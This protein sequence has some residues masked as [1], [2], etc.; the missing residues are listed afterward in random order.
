MKLEDSGVDT[1]VA[2]LA[3]NDTAAHDEDGLITEI[4]AFFDPQQAKPSE[5]DPDLRR[6]NRDRFRDRQR[7]QNVPLKR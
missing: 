4:V 6:H 2:Q 5:N 3:E 1:V 7:Q